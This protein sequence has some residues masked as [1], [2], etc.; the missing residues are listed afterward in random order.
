MLCALGIRNFAVIEDAHLEFGDALTALTGESGAG[1]S[2]VVEALMLA[3]GERADADAV[4]A[5]CARA[6]VSATFDLADAPHLRAWLGE[7]G[8]DTAG[9]CVLR[10]VVSAEGRSRSFVN[11]QPVTAARVRELGQRL[12]EIHGQHAYQSLLRPEHQQDLLDRYGGHE[13]LVAAVRAAHRT[14]RDATVAL[15]AAS[16]DAAHASARRAELHERLAALDALGL[17]AGEWAELEAEQVRLGHLETLAQGAG[18]ALAL[19]EGDDGTGAGSLASKAGQ[20]LAR[21]AGYDATL[22][23]I[24]HTLE[25]ALAELRAAVSALRRYAAA[26]EPDPQ[27][28]RHVDERLHAGLALARRYGVAPET[29]PDLHEA[30]RAEL[31]ALDDPAHTGAALAARCDAALAAYRDAAG[32][33]S[34][35]RGAAAA[36]LEAAVAK[37]L[38]RLAMHEARFVVVLEPDASDAPPL[39]RGAERV[40]L[41]LAPHPGA[42]ALPLGRVASGGELSR[43]SLAI[44]VA[45]LARGGAP[46]VVLDE[47]DVGIGG[48]T[49]GE[50]GRMLRRLATQRQVLCVT[51]LPQMAAHAHHHLRVVREAH[52]NPPAAQVEPLRGAARIAELARMLGGDG[53]TARAHA[54]ELLT[55]AVQGA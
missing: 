16:A 14:W 23:P 27:R 26:L 22:A 55:S 9:E 53:P 24:A 4:R 42:N 34:A 8:L 6:E 18:E 13:T 11:D 32:A 2:M 50:V 25:G 12:I 5:G 38:A 44:E 17:G 43:L 28:A 36:R 48:L 20:G 51:H 47:V 35:A 15:Q 52:G 31:A 7:A 49:A 54:R 33:L 3:L 30:V 19:L 45:A 39:A 1:K 21:L 46:T 37:E 10:R 29:L 40:E 41:R